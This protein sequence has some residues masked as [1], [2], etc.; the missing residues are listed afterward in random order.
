MTDKRKHLAGE[1]RRR[2]ETPTQHWERVESTEEFIR[3][4]R[5]Y[6]DHLNLHREAATDTVID[7]FHPRAGGAIR[8]DSR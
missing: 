5:E 8:S 1:L 7:L 6:L 3:D 4:A 2:L